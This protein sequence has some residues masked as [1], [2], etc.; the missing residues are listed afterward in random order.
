MSSKVTFDELKT[1]LWGAADILR[2]SL[3]A[4]EYRQPIMTILFLK[5]LTDQFEERAEQFEQEGKTKKQAWDDPDYHPFF[6]PQKS[7]WNVI[8]STF[9]N[10]GEVIDHACLSIEKSNPSLEGV[11]TN[12]SYNDKK[13]FPDDDLLS[14]V[15]H[16]NEKR[17]R[18][19]DLSNED[20]FGQAYEYLLEK[21]AD[22]A[23]KQAGEFFTPR[24]VVKTLVNLL[25]PEENMKICDP[26]CGSGGMLI[27]SRE[28]INKK[29][30]NPKNLSLHGQERNFGNFAMCKMNMILHDIENFRIEHEN[31]LSTPLLVENGSLIKYDMVMANF[32]FSMEWKKSIVQN[33]KYDR[34]SLCHPPKNYADF[35]FIQHIFSIL[36]DT[37]RAAIIASQG[38]LYR[39]GDEEK[40]RKYLVDNDFLDGIIS[41]PSN[42]FYGTGI[43]ACIFLLNKKKPYSR[44]NKITFIYAA[45]E[46]LEI[47]KKSLLDENHIKK[48][49]S[50]FKKSKNIDGYCHIT[51][52]DEIKF[53]DYNLNVPRYVDTIDSE[54]PINIKKT[55]TELIKV[56]DSRPNLENTL[57][58]NL[59][60][61]I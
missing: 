53:N 1:H 29:G 30:G 8:S 6:I 19:S 52:I 34:F 54:V 9:E 24:E 60:K 4:S 38:V 3:D 58:T 37:G 27:W 13:R 41:L 12:I 49:V 10:I 46:F 55:I 23:G 25:E 22:S 15:S 59:K 7:R 33:D 47:D 44:K 18:N 16:F 48:I 5:R 2:G 11:L 36:T 35:L 26:T 45:K 61:W 42:L 28:F 43:P 20:I 14:L 40:I 32:P 50:T 39:G 56:K 21:F 17:L 51:N 31:V 57:F